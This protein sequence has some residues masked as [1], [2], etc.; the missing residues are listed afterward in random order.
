MSK[1]TAGSA[2]LTRR[3]ALKGAAVV[4]AT[5]WVAPVVQVISMESAAAAS[6]PPASVQPRTGSN[7]PLASGPLS[8]GTLPDTGASG[9]TGGIAAA[10]LAAV[11]AGAGAVVIA[12]RRP[13]AATESAES[14]DHS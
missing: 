2:S 1:N 10:G 9:S 4:G 8:G 13:T 11:V 12:R 5:A 3:T 6:S 14:A 7:Q